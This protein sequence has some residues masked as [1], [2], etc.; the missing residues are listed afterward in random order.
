MPCW[1]GSGWRACWAVAGK[2]IIRTLTPDHTAATKLGAYNPR[3]IR[4]LL[5]D[6]EARSLRTFHDAEQ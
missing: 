4:D 3:Q 1:T 6:L 2:T 5:S